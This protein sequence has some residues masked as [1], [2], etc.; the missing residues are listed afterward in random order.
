MERQGAT[1]GVGIAGLTSLLACGLATPVAAQQH[2]VGLNVAY[3]ETNNLGLDSGQGV[4]SAF[5]MVGLDLAL[6]HESERVISVLNGDV[7]EYHYAAA[8][9]LPTQKQVVGSLDGRLG[10]EIVPDRFGWDFA[11]SFGQARTNPLGPIGPRN[12]ERVT[13][14]STGPRAT[15][16]LGNRNS[17]DLQGRVSDR[18]F[19]KSDL[20][21]A[22]VTAGQVG[23]THNIS[24]VSQ[25]G[26]DISQSTTDFANVDLRYDV[27]NAYVS[28]SRQFAS[29][30]IQ[31]RIGTGQVKIGSSS[32]SIG[33]MNFSWNRLLGARSRFEVTAGHEFTDAGEIFRLG[34]VPGLGGTPIGTLTRLGPV[35]D[36]TDV[37]DAR[38]RDVL[39]NSNPVQ[40]T[41]AG[42]G[43]NVSGQRTRMSI[44]F[45][46]SKDQYEDTG[47]NNA[48]VLNNDA[49]RVN[50]VLT[51]I[52]NPR[53]NATLQV[54][55]WRRKFVDTTQADQDL[56]ERIDVARE[57]TQRAS[58]QFAVQHNERNK[59]RSPYKEDVYIVLFHYDLTR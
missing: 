39:L 17:L 51:R 38:S 6:G 35:R 11:E 7:A 56:R 10:L 15:I 31:T 47:S 50:F 37:T 54:R 55:E 30:G 45:G 22:R 48:L 3:G 52:F 4:S 1:L 59:G 43:F 41:S 29:G 33:V 58:L 25:L 26:V 53:W 5:N 36:I 34:G 21:D 14:V 18:S 8:G 2:G 32:S 49:Q 57:L 28:Y 46:M 20:L 44:G 12:R 40:R 23:F 27:D 24:R 9:V 42:I 16:P 13:V 19:Q